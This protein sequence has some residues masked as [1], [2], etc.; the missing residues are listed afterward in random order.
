MVRLESSK[1]TI[2]IV[3]D[4]LYLTELYKEVLE[5]EGY[6]VFLAKSGADALTMMKDLPTPDLL[7]VDCF[8]PGMSGAEFLTE[9]FT[10]FPELREKCAV[11]GFSGLFVESDLL[12]EMR[13]LVS[14]IVEK[15]NDLTDVIQLVQENLPRV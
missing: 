8:M 4:Q 11:V 14:K 5:Q 1:K 12:S 10:E 13:A 3:D 7:L 15:P 9:L 6:G 2:F